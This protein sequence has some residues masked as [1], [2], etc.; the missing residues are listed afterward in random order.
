M[1]L[2]RKVLFKVCPTQESRIVIGVLVLLALYLYSGSRRPPATFKTTTG[3]DILLSQLSV[4]RSDGS[5]NVSLRAAQQDLARKLGAPLPV[6]TIFNDTTAPQRVINEWI[7][8]AYMING[9]ELNDMFTALRSWLFFRNFPLHVHVVAEESLFPLIR[10]G[11]MSWR[12]NPK[13]F[14]HSVYSMDRCRELISPLNEIID[15]SWPEANLCKLTLHELIPKN[16]SF[17]IAM[18]TNVWITSPAVINTCWKSIFDRMAPTDAYIGVVEHP[19]PHPRVFLDGLEVWPAIDQVDF[20]TS[21]LWLDLDRMRS[22]RFLPRFQRETE[23]HFSKHLIVAPRGERDF[24]NF[25]RYH[26]PEFVSVVDCNCNF[27]L[28]ATT[29]EARNARCP[30]STPIYIAQGPVLAP[31]PVANQTLDNST[32]SA[33]ISTSPSISP[34]PSATP[35]S[36]ASP[37]LPPPIIP[38]YLPGDQAYHGLRQYFLSLRSNRRALR[39]LNP[40]NCYP[41]RDPVTKV[42][43]P[44]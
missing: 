8:V 18:D 12:M 38:S 36:P 34:Y 30:D 40:Y 28:T 44:C 27:P 32:V 33:S 15:P 42:V 14:R 39:R 31:K 1:R 9:T 4:F 11:M 21:V 7:H 43:E 29:L 24:F 16:V 19:M 41:L 6:C 5:A 23:V 17:V 37:S 10:S 25:I 22:N 20:D 35:L 13:N 2:Y 3:E 26:E